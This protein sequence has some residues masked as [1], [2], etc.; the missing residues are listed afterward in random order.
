MRSRT[1]G[2]AANTWGRTWTPAELSNGNFRIRITNVAN[3]TS[4]DFTLDWAA[5]RISY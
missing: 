2:G 5:V 3:S 1:L 4:R